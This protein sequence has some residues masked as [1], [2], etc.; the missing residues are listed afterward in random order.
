MGFSYYLILQC[1]V[2]L[3]S[4]R[5]ARSKGS[6][7]LHDESEFFN[8]STFSGNTFSY[9]LFRQKETN[10]I[11]RLNPVSWF[12]ILKLIICSH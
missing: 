10:R 11:T 7:N 2:I 3:K 4:V 9:L 5:K 8:F 12:S 1:I 6:Y